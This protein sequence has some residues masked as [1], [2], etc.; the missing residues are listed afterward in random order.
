MKNTNMFPIVR[1]KI[2]NENL[3]VKSENESESE[4]EL[5]ISPVGDI[6]LSP[7]NEA[8]GTAT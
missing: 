1:K 7:T 3:K 2:E 5:L 6:A 8:R 4:S